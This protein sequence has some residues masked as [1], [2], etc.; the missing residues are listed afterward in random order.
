MGVLLV[1]DLPRV[2][3][4]Q[5]GGGG[6]HVHGVQDGAA[7][8]AVGRLRGLLGGGPG[9]QQAGQQGQEQQGGKQS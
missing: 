3:I 6:I 7:A 9:G 2:G 4:H 5:D 1:E 8:A